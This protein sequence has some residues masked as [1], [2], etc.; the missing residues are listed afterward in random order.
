MGASETPTSKEQRMVKWNVY[1]HGRLITSVFYRPDCDAEYIR[2]GLT[3]HDGM[4]P[5]IKVRRATAGSR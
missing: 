3:D 5:A 1:L 2:V 4:H